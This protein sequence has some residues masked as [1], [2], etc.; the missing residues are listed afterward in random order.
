ME[1]NNPVYQF[2]KTLSLQEGCGDY[3]HFYPHHLQPCPHCYTLISLNSQNSS[4]IPDSTSLIKVGPSKKKRNYTNKKKEASK[5][6]SAAVKSKTGEYFKFYFCPWI[7]HY[8]TYQGIS[9]T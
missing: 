2:N 4:P 1:N 9:F 5:N 8:N 3:S 6:I 7:I